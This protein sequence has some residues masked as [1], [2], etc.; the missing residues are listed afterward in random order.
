[1]QREATGR[2]NLAIYH[3]ELTGGRDAPHD[4]NI[5]EGRLQLV[6]DTSRIVRNTGPELRIATESTAVIF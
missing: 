2:V 3:L 4:L 6:R 5:R 1:M